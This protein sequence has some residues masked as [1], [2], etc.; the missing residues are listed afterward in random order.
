MWEILFHLLEPILRVFG[1]VWSEDE[2]PEAR[3]FSVGCLVLVLGLIGL[4]VWISTR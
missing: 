2:R 3:W 4:A 1:I